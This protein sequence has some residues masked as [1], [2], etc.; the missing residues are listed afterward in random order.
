[1]K[2]ADMIAEA[3]E[4]TI[5]SQELNQLRTSG[6]AKR[7]YNLLERG[8]DSNNGRAGSYD[9]VADTILSAI[10]KNCSGFVVDIANRFRDVSNHYEMSQK[11]MWC[12]A[13]AFL[14][15]ENELDTNTL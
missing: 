12:C 11:Q 15:I 4:R 5:T 2:L 1:M 10:A 14:K 13:F 9:F 6:D 8:W 3:H 7:V